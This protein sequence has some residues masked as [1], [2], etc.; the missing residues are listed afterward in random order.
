MNLRLYTNI[1]VWF[2]YLFSFKN[3]KF[4]K[5]LF[6]NMSVSKSQ[7]YQD[8][9]VIFFSNFKKNGIFIEIGG[10]NGVDLSNTYVHEKKFF[11]SGLICEPARI[12]QKNIKLNRRA[13][14]EKR[15][16][17]KLSKIN[18]IFYENH[19]PYQSSLKMSNLNNRKYRTNSLSLNSLIEFHKIGQKIDY[20]SV[21]TEGNEF[22]IISNFNFKKYEV[23][24]FTVEHNF[25]SYKREKILKVMK[26]NGFKRVF[27]YLSYMDDWYINE[28][29]IAIKDF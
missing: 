18:T 19:D 26:K 10:G 1:K 28:K 11:W 9:F 5:Y 3:R 24:F 22:D 21:D 2:F 17:S 14:L 15:P 16:I 20:I 7:V 29:N 4:F 6:K 8:L 13:K 27:K 23:N 12:L 25:N